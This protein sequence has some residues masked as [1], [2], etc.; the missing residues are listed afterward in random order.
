MEREEFI[1]SLSLGLAAA[2]AGSCFI[3]CTKSGTVV[4]AVPAGGGSAALATVD[5]T[6]IPNLGD[7]VI[8]GTV[9]VFRIAAANVP[10][11]FIATEAACPHQGGQ[12][13]WLETSKFIQCQLHQ[14]EYKTDGSVIQGPQGIAGA[15]RSL[16]IYTVTISGTTLNAS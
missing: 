6:T 2:C 12:L 14:S 8:K 13:K 16:K 11:S 15:T 1:R 9:L 10:A 5:I 7:Q 4:P 3:A